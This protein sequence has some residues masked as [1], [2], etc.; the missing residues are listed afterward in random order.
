MVTELRV[1]FEGDKA[2]RPGFHRFLKEIIEAARG[3]RCKF[4]LVEAN[5]A[6]SRTS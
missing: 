6:Q 1:Y 5:G 3:Q 2:L 4:Q